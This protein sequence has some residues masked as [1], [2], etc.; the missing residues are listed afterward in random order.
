MSQGQIGLAQRSSSRVDSVESLNALLD[1]EGI[2]GELVG[3]VA[4]VTNLVELGQV[5]EMTFIDRPCFRVHL[6]ESADEV[7]QPLLQKLMD[8]DP[9]VVTLHAGLLPEPE[10]LCLHVEEEIEE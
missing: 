7:V 9:T 6:G 5:S 1:A 4:I 10:L 8:A 3:L 2:V